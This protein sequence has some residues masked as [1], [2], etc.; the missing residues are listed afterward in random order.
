MYAY[1][2]RRR[3][4]KKLKN[5]KDNRESPDFVE[6]ITEIMHVA[7]FSEYRDENMFI[8]SKAFSGGASMK[9]PTVLFDGSAFNSYYIMPLK[10][11]ASEGDKHSKPQT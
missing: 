3:L 4:D 8:K 6:Y 2:A 11:F 5:T 9:V 10:F 7:N 1:S